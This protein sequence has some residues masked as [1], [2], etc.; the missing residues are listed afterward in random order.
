MGAMA[1]NIYHWESND[2]GRLDDHAWHPRDVGKSLIVKCTADKYL[3]KE[4]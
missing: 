3:E 4:T 1:I 2:W